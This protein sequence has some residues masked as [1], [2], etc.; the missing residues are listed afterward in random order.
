[1]VTG[2]ATPAVVIAVMASPAGPGLMILGDGT[3]SAR[4]GYVSSTVTVWTRRQLPSR[5][6]VLRFLVLCR[7]DASDS[8]SGTSPV[9]RRSP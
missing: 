8:S 3:Q 1:M 2:G 7:D 4:V 5:C 9:G 6:N